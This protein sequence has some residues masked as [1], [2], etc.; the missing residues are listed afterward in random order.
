MILNCRAEK[1]VLVSQTIPEVSAAIEQSESRLEQIRAL[2]TF[3]AERFAEE[4]ATL[5]RLFTD[6]Q[7]TNLKLR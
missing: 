3:D 4:T 7:K 2:E 6:E 5:A 1:E